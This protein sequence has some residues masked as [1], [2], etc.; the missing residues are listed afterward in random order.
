MCSICGLRRCPPPCPSYEGISWE[1]GRP[2][3]SCDECGAYIYPDEKHFDF[4]KIILCADCSAE[5]EDT[6]QAYDGKEKNDS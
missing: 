2:I 6:E 3:G 5:E 1:S 4:G